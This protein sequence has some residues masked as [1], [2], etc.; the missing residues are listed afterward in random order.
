VEY[1][2]GVTNMGTVV[3]DGSRLIRVWRSIV[4]FD[5]VFG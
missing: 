4:L 5:E 3:G 1:V 2:G